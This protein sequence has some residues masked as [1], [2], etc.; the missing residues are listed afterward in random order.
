MRLERS[1]RRRE[2]PLNE[3]RKNN[4]LKWEEEGAERKG[5]DSKEDDE[6]T[7]LY[8]R[9]QLPLRMKGSSDE[10]VSQPLA[11]LYSSP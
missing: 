6:R 7:K 10:S 9:P 3:R 4:V 11:P 8:V 5:E 1:V 2:S